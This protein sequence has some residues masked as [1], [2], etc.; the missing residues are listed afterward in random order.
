ML[1]RGICLS[2]ICSFG[3]LF[4]HLAIGL[5]KK[6]RDKNEP[7]IFEL[8]RQT[9]LLL[10]IWSLTFL[11]YVI[12]FLSPLVGIEILINKSNSIAQVL[13]FLY[14][15][16]FFTILCFMYLTFYY[17][18]DRSVSATILEIIENSPRKR[19]TSD[20][21]KQIY[22]IEAK[23]QSELKGMLDG[24]FIIKESGYYRNTLKGHLYSQIARFMKR[25]LKLGSGG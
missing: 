22:N 19:L 3:S 25:Y 24:G 6:G 18:A 17:D 23:Y 1:I 5:F 9:K 12:L 21:I 8:I 7:L 2:L 10:V 13:N 4:I 14:G 20:E 11:I 16:V 15:I